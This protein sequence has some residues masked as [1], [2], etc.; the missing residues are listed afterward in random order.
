MQVWLEVLMLLSRCVDVLRDVLNSR[1]DDPVRQSLSPNGEG[2]RMTARS[3]AGST[4]ARVR[5][6]DLASEVARVLRQL[7]VIVAGLAA[8]ALVSCGDA[9]SAFDEV[10]Q[11]ARIEQGIPTLVFVYTDG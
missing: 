6:D 9:G 10:E 5:T 3:A 8:L 7:A 4:P 11:V 2:R 1:N